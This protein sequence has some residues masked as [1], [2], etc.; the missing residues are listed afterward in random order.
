MGV[1]DGGD[2][3][4]VGCDGGGWCGREGRD[5]GEG[6]VGGEKRA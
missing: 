5:G 1:K 3:V 6:E 2:G 4:G